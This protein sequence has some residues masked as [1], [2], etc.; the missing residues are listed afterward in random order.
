M[1]IDDK[2]ITPGLNPIDENSI[3]CNADNITTNVVIYI[4][5]ILYAPGGVLPFLHKIVIRKI[6]NRKRL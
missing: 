3:L 4:I 2:C 1:E 5:K 6:S